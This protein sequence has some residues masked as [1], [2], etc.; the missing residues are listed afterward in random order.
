MK[1]E[2]LR[3]VF[4]IDAEVVADPRT[5]KPVCIT[6]DLLTN[7]RQNNKFAHKRS[8]NLNLKAKRG[9]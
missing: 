4:N 9:L 6:Y 8:H 3:G 1:P 2:V 7:S 5:N